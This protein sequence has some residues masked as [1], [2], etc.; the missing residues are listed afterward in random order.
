MAL[1]GDLRQS[2]RCGAVRCGARLVRTDRELHERAARASKAAHAADGDAEQA[3]HGGAD[4]HGARVLRCGACPGLERRPRPENLD[5][6]CPLYRA[7]GSGQAVLVLLG[8]A[9]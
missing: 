3:E 2:V 4:E 8:L 6:S 9:P 1:I 5:C 7:G